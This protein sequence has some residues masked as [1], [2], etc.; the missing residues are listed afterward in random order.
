MLIQIE[1]LEKIE[2]WVIQIL[3]PF[4]KELGCKWIY[5]IKYHSHGSVW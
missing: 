2:T 1:A 5:K 4:N 3:P